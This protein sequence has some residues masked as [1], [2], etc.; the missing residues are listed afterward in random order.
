ME[1]LAWVQIEGLYAESNG[2][3]I[4]ERMIED[5]TALGR[6]LHF[7]TFSPAEEPRRRVVTLSSTLMSFEKAAGLVK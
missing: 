6:S 7:S 5:N 2:V 4:T 3:R 1:K